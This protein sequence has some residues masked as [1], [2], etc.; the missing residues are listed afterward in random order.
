MNITADTVL[1]RP[2]RMQAPI[3]RFV[4]SS[5]LAYCTVVE[6]KADDTVAVNPSWPVEG[7][8]SGERVAWSLLESLVDGDLRLAFDKLDPKNV[9]ALMAALESLYAL[10]A[11]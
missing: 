8:S 10:V 2:D 7:F 3:V 6:T 1:I 5:A 4:E 9:G 11:S